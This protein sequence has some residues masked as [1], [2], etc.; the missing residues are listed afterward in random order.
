VAGRLSELASR[1]PALPAAQADAA[2]RSD[3][4]GTPAFGTFAFD[5]RGE[6]VI[7]LAIDHV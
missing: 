7:A 2:F 1:R 4:E 6:R 5:D 3:R